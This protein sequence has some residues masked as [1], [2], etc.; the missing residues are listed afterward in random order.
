V[1]FIPSLAVHSH[2]LLTD[3]EMHKFNAAQYSFAA[4]A[5]NLLWKALGESKFE[6]K[7]R[8]LGRQVRVEHDPAAFG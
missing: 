4:L 3:N 6:C 2:K 5:R 7:N 8:Q 1:V